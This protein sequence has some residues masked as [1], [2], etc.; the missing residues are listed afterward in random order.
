MTDD[1]TWHAGQIDADARAEA[2]G[3]RGAVVWLTGLSGSGK[4]TLAVEV[5]RRLVVSGRP[6]FILDGDN[7]RHGLCADLGF[8]EVDRRENIRRVGEVALL[9]AEAA[10][11]VLVPLISPYRSGRD[12]VRARAELAGVPF[13]EVWVATPLAECEARDPKGLYAKARAGE[14]SNFTGID[15]PYE[16]PLQPELVVGGAAA[17]LATSA[18]SSEMA[19]TLDEQADAII[20]LL[21]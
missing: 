16:E 18:A 13:R 11:V 9:M 20:A 8:S 4:S 3:H 6:S 12:A 5:E 14:I 10:Q 19:S 1:V 7:V 15:D 17:S 2:L 21:G